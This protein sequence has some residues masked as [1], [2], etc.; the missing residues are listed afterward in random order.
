MQESAAYPRFYPP[1]LFGPQEV[2]DLRKTLNTEVEGLRSEF[3]ELKTALKQQL[4]LT[5]GLAS[6]VRIA[7]HRG[8]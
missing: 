6:Q 7:G 2:G 1:Q 5:A 8:W 3:M 4:E